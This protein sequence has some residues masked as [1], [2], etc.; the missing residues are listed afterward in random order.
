[1][2]TNFTFTQM[3]FYLLAISFFGFINFSNA[4]VANWVG[5]VDTDF[6][7]V[8]NWD[9]PKI[10]FTN[11]VTTNVI[12][13]AGTPNNPVNIG[14]TGNETMPKRPATLTTN[15]GANITVIG[16]FFPN[17]LSNMNGTITVDA[18]AALFSVRNQAYLGKGAVGIL[19][20][21]TGKAAVKNNFFIGN[22]TGGDGLVT[23]N[24]GTLL[25]ILGGLELGTGAGDPTGNLKIKG[26][27]TVESSINIGINGHVSI[28]G[29]GKL[30]VSGNK[31]EVLKAFVKSRTIGC[32][33]GKRLQVVFDGTKTTVNIS[34]GVAT[35]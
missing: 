23:V 16:N 32:T 3:R 35:K 21:N 12:I 4:Q 1:M 19:N 15:V 10:D 27:V 14:Y 34:E 28:S 22:G 6:Y 30:I 20:I 18:P 9:Y 13:G 11:L 7:N 33:V 25:E 24:S 2:K 31:E 26:T 29:T 8:K 17:G 5:G